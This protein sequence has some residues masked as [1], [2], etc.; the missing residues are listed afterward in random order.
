MSYRIA[1][2][3]I[4]SLVTLLLGVTRKIYRR[5]ACALRARLLVC[6]SRRVIKHL[7]HVLSIFETSFLKNLFQI[8]GVFMFLQI[9]QLSFLGTVHPESW[10]SR[11]LRSCSV[12]LTPEQ[13]FKGKRNVSL[14]QA[15]P[16]HMLHLKSPKL[17]RVIQT[18]CR[19]TLT[20]ENC[21][22]S[23]FTRYCED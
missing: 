12:I 1:G 11:T 19:K 13:I 10:S 15:Q 23:D 17:C 16:A 6:L 22:S 20:L 7:Q 5:S 21:R 18:T 8:L 14:L 3:Q 2:G 4:N 9:T